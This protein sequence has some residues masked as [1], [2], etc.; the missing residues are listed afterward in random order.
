MLVAAA[1][2]RYAPRPRGHAHSSQSGAALRRDTFLISSKTVLL[3][4]FDHQWRHT[5]C[6][7][8]AKSIG[9]LSILNAKEEAERLRIRAR[10]KVPNLP[11]V[12][13]APKK[14]TPAMLLMLR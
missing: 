11:L 14:A 1:G 7:Y 5:Q 13:Q 3:D 6:Q 2:G 12:A 8:A 4:M 9:L 10:E